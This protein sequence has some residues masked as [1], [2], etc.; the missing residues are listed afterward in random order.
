MHLVLF[1]DRLSFQIGVPPL[2]IYPQDDIWNMNASEAP[3]TSSSGNPYHGFNQDISTPGI[4]A[5]AHQSLSI[6]GQN[7]EGKTQLHIA[8]IQVSAEQVKSLLVAGAAVDIKDNS[9]YGPLHYAVLSENLTIVKD[10][11]RFGADCNAK[12]RGG[13]SPLHLATSSLQIVD[14]LLL[15]GAS[16]SAQD[17][18]G[19]TPLH[20][21][22]SME[23]DDSSKEPIIEKFINFR[24]NVNLANNKGFTPFHRLLER[25]QHTNRTLPLL[26]QFLL[27][28]A[29]INFPFP[30]GRLP[31]HHFL[32]VSKN[33]WLEKPGRWQPENTSNGVFKQFLE[34]GADPLTPVQSLGPLA[35]ALIR[36][37]LYH[38]NLDPT[39]AEL[40]CTKVSTGPVISNGNSFL[41]EL[42]SNLRNSSNKKHPVERLAETL[43]Q[44]GADPNLLNQDGQ[45]PLTLLFDGKDNY[46]PTTK[47]VASILLAQGANIMLGDK[48]GY[49]VLFKA[50]KR[51]TWE[52][53][54]PLVRADIKQREGAARPVATDSNEWCYEWEK[55]VQA[56][57]WDEARDLIL[58]CADLIPP[59]IE[60]K[61]RL[62]TLAAIA[63]KHVDLVKSMFEGD[64]L[65]VEMRRKYLVTILRDC[66]AQRIEIDM[67][68]VDYL[69]EL[70]D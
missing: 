27:S 15:N 49:A 18:N 32:T 12:D 50:A 8:V 45:S 52:E 1:I 22:L 57:S 53:L 55:I 69:L 68:H 65:A 23:P 64:I 9:G 60:E 7:S 29:N 4:S 10:L 37:K 34:K 61:I 30:D 70:C 25:T 51:L 63:E 24:S 41:H 28:G 26:R 2:L 58:N 38:W 47:K 48:N 42:C 6:D 14:T 33:K 67:A 66:R 5:P 40:L 56:Q 36:H 46:L 54:K 20:L 3:H 62:S 44:Q 39:I 43:L 59:D 21:V 11:L 13:R 17:E 31:F 35:V 19:D 16:V